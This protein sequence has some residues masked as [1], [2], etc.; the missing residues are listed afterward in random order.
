MRLSRR[1][2]PAGTTDDAILL[3]VARAVRAFGDGFVSVLLPVYLL[4]LGFDAVAVGALSTS[5]LLGSAALTLLVGLQA[6]RFGRR[7]LLLAASVLMAATGLAFA[8]VHAFWPLLLIAFVGTLN[9]SSGDVSVFLPL[10]QSLLPQTATAKARTALFARYSVAGTLAAAVGALCAGVPAVLAAHT[11]LDTTGAVQVLFVVYGL[12]GLVAFALYRRLSPTAEPRRVEQAPLRESKRTV[13][14][15][16]G[17]FSLDAFG[18]GLVVQSLLALW[19]FQRFDLSLQSAGSLFFWTGVLAAVS[20]LL[21][22]PLAERFGLINTMVY[23]HLPSNVLLALVPFMPNLPLA[24]ALLLA[25]SALSQMDVPTRASY[26]MAVV[27]PAERPAAASVTAVPRSLAS[28]LGPLPAGFL[29]ALS[30]FGWPLVIAGVL[31][32]AYDVLL[33]AMFARVRPPEEQT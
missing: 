9:P 5:T 8:T 16:A 13:F 30:P 11:P 14:T 15:L 1:L 33:L 10:E 24:I 31:K 21:A 27:P 22:V 18:G 4:G 19:L 6:N 32:G 12:L 17:L 3:L 28:A 23:T 29:L 20:F 26:V 7:G 2:L 25:R